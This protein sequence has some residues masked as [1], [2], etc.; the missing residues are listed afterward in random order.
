MK[1]VVE[2]HKL[3]IIHR[4]LKPA[5][6]FLTE[7]YKRIKIGDMNIS[8]V[9]KHDLTKTQIGTPYYL[10]PEIW[11]KQAYDYK[12][13][14]F[15]LGV[16]IFELAALKHPFKG[17]SAY[18]LGK[19]IVFEKAPLLPN[20]YSKE[21]SYIVNKCL[22][23]D[24]NKR[25]SAIEVLEH[26]LV[27]KMVNKYKLWNLMSDSGLGDCVLLDTIKIPRKLVNI[28]DKLPKRALT[29]SKSEKG[30]RSQ[31]KLQNKIDKL[32]K[33][34]IECPVDEYEKTN[35]LRLKSSKFYNKLDTRISPAKRERKRVKTNLSCASFNKLAS[36]N[37][38]HKIKSMRGQGVKINMRESEQRRVDNV[39]SQ[40]TPRNVKDKDIVVSK[41]NLV[42]KSQK[43]TKPL[44]LDKSKLPSKLSTFNDSVDKKDTYKASPSIDKIRESSPEFDYKNFMISIT[45]NIKNSRLKIKKQKIIKRSNSANIALNF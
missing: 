21:L 12:V 24:D 30:K 1:G 7:D 3:K 35:K 2:L 5:N 13:D 43:I 15:S 37:K 19:K 23:K 14:I 33:D 39:S 22:I 29:R 31:G 6:I 20:C 40:V 34:N 16:L 8:K 4:D 26:R 25:P 28:N 42:F 36:Y 45:N 41:S 11:N 9:L 18:E 44:V 32:V 27:G 17:E 10:A 38:I